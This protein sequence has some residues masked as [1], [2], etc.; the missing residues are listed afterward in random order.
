VEVTISTYKKLLVKD[1]VLE[2]RLARLSD[3]VLRI[4]RI[5]GIPVL[6][7]VLLYWF[8]T[9]SGISR[10]VLLFIVAVFLFMGTVQ[11]KREYAIVAHYGKAVGTVFV[12]EKP[13]L[14]RGVRIEYG[15]LSADDKLYIG[16]VSG[17][18]FLPK[19]G[20]TIPVVYKIEDPSISLPVG[21]FWFY[22]FP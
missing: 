15:F 14:R 21:S 18:A 17:S 1:E 13:G 12:R 8:V 16:E 11:L 3:P 2:K 20:Q 4:T 7:A 6:C 19:E 9:E 22:D 5:L 10:F